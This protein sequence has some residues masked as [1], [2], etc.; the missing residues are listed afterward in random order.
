[1]TTKTLDTAVQTQLEPSLQKYATS[2]KR[3]VTSLQQILEWADEDVMVAAVELE[4]AKDDTVRTALKRQHA[5]KLGLYEHL[6]GLLQ[7][8]TEEEHWAKNANVKT[9]LGV[10]PD[11]TPPP[12]MMMEQAPPPP[13]RQPEP[14]QQQLRGR[15]RASAYPAMSWV[16]QGNLGL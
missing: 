15:G 13:Q 10:E 16:G 12:W 3:A 9:R 8:A 2:T 6:K 14:V 5:F 11:L 7:T 4:K 1:M